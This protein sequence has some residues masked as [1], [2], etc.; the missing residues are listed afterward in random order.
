MRKLC[1]LTVAAVCLLFNFCQK[2]KNQ[3]EKSQ[4]EAL[5][6]QSNLVFFYYPDLE[7]AEN[8]L[9]DPKNH[10]IRELLR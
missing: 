1:V 4:S 7:E 3:M 10:R 6:I 8:F 5:S 9:E 2:G